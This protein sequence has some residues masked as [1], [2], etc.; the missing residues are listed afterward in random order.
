MLEARRSFERQVLLTTIGYR[1]SRF[2]TRS[3]TRV[4]EA[5]TRLSPQSRYGYF[6]KS[7][8]V[9]YNERLSSESKIRAADP[10]FPQFPY[11]TEVSKPISSLVAQ[12]ARAVALTKFRFFETFRQ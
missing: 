6:S 12:S 10:F 2:Q 5:R 4:H 3:A 8:G 1:Y 7:H 11:R 9:F